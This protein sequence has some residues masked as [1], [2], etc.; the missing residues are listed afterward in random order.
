MTTP[1]IA[2]VC[3]AGTT[4]RGISSGNSHSCIQFHSVFP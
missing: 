4:I 2:G 3:I 1:D